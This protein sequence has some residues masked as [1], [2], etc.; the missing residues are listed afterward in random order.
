MRGFRIICVGKVK[1]EYFR[2][3]IASYLKEIRK[4]YPIDILE[5]PDEPTPENAS[6]TVEEQIKRVEGE[7]ILSKISAEDYV[8]AL[9]IDG[10]QYSDDKWLGHVLRDMERIDG[11]YDF[12]IGG[13]LG[14]SG[15]VMNR[16]DDKISFSRMTFPHQ[17][18]R[19]ILCEQIAKLTS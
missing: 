16:A 9:C 18:M 2:D 8:S 11:Y 15:E 5:C 19:M 17:M 1:E 14:L 4:A 12:V 6:S 7:R 3:G 13:S 10:K